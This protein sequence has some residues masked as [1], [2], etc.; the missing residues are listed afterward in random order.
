M[1]KIRTI[2]LPSNLLGPWLPG[3]AYGLI[4]IVN[5]AEAEGIET[6]PDF[7]AASRAKTAIRNHERR[8]G[9]DP[10]AIDIIHITDWEE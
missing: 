2:T 8:C 10:E 1:T 6:Q 4:R 5:E 3:D 7:L 9:R